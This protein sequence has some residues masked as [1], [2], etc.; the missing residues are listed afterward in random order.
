M[1]VKC[2]KLGRM[3]TPRV[4]V[5]ASDGTLIGWV[6]GDGPEVLLL[7]GGPGLSF[8]YLNGLAAEIGPGYRVA[9][10]QQRG[11]APS[12][13]EGPYDVAQHVVDAQAVL[14]ALGWERAWVVGHSWGG[15]VLLHLAA[16]APHRLRGGLAVDPLGGVGDGGGARFERELLARTPKADWQRAEELDARAMQGEGTEAD[17]VESMRL[18]WPAYFASR[19]HVMAF[20]AQRVSVD[21]YAE[22]LASAA[23]ELPALQAAL[24]GIAVPLGFVAG[25]ASPMPADEAAGA[26]A[27]AIPGAWLEVVD[28]AGHFPWHERPGSVRAALERLV[29]GAVIVT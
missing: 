12:T 20:S 22:G 18:V 5:S 29:P 27:S 23:A 25:A 7:H 4:E 16:A 3:Q 26:T 1:G 6:Q 8:E 10:Y 15:H 11:L 24:A 21:A 19:D 2:V 17:M 28:G 13:V 9:S 14:D